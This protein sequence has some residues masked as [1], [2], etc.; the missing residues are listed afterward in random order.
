MRVQRTASVAVRY[1]AQ[2]ERSD[3]CPPT[4]HRRNLR[5]LYSNVSV[6][7][8]MVGAVATTDPSVILYI[9]VVLPALSSLR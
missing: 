1:C 7:D 2:L 5:F 6:F 4:S 8:P 3:V 9:N